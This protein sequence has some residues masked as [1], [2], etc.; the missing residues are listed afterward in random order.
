MRYSRSTAS[1]CIAFATLLIEPVPLPGSQSEVTRDRDPSIET[2]LQSA[3]TA[4]VANL[5]YFGECTFDPKPDL[6]LC[7]WPGSDIDFAASERLRWLF[8]E[9]IED[10]AVLCAADTAIVRGL[11][12]CLPV[13]GGY[14]TKL[15]ELMIRLAPLWAQ[16]GAS[17]RADELFRTANT[18]LSNTDELYPLKRELWRTWAETSAAQGRLQWAKELAERFIA[19]QRKE[20]ET[21]HVGRTSLIKGLTLEANILSQLGLAEEAK[22]RREE[23]DALSALPDHPKICRGT[24]EG[25]TVCR[26]KA[27]GERVD[28]IQVCGRDKSGKPICWWDEAY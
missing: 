20:Y 17:D 14:I 9:G 28:L 15:A 11:K 21:H 13:E 16:Q 19:A 27:P 6:A 4:S 1:I 5:D 23:L 7:E 25:K 10:A 22:A 3:D 8:Y 24:P 18:L 26:P 2:S 12:E